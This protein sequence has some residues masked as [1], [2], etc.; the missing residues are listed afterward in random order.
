V[1]A[2]QRTK[3]ASYERE[4]VNEL[5]DLLGPVVRRCWERASEKGHDIDLPGFA[6][7]C[8][9]Y[10]KIAVHAWM[11]QAVEQARNGDTPLVIMRADRKESL[12]LM[13]LTDWV[14]LAREEICAEA[15]PS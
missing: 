5:R 12:V 14:K 4:V 1:S 7:E 11:D 6:V 10:A 13:R 15:D 3:G 2:M 8:K 9:R